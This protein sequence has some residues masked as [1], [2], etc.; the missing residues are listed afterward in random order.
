VPAPLA[1]RQRAMAAVQAALRG[2]TVARPAPGFP[3]GAGFQSQPVDPAPDGSPPP[4]SRPAAQ[5]PVVTLDAPRAPADPRALASLLAEDAEAKLDQL[6]Y[7]WNVISELEPFAAPGEPSLRRRAAELFVVAGG[8]APDV[9]IEGPLR[10]ARSFLDAHGMSEAYIDRLC[11][12][13]LRAT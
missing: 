13:Y 10:A 4:P 3:S 1:K 2:S 5:S 12:W 7:V 8:G 9:P 11:E 6:C